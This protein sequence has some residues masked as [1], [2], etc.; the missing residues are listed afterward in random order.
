MAHGLNFTSSVGLWPTPSPQGE[1]KGADEIFALNQHNFTLRET[2]RPLS[3]PISTRRGDHRSPAVPALMEG[4]GRANAICVSVQISCA[5][6]KTTP[7]SLL[8]Q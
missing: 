5:S 1:G 8:S 7:Q 6:E 2:P 4:T 3:E